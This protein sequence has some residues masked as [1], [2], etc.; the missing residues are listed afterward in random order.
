MKQILEGK[1]AIVTGSGQGIGRCIAL[2]MAS[3]GAKVITNNRKPGSSINAFEHTD[4]DFTDEEREELLKFN[5][6]A[7]TTADEII[8]MGGEAYPVFGD[9]SN[10]ENA[11]KLVDTA[12]E[13]WG[14]VDIIVNNA[15]S[16]W[17][18]NIMDMDVE[19]WDTQI[20]S[21]L[22]GTFY[23]MYYALPHMKEQGYGRII[24]S[25]SDAFVGI[26]DYAAYGAGN[27]GVVALS[28]AASK[29]LAGTG[30]TVNSYTP[31]ARTRSWYNARTSYR[32]Q[33]ISPDMIES[34]APEAMKRT[35]EGMVPF[36][37]YLASDLA[38]DITG[39][40]F[41]LAADGVIGLWSD[42]EIVKIIKDGSDKWTVEELE[43]RIK[44]EL[45]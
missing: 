14:R 35:A 13:K 26:N 36:L 27:A 43:K 45:L 30:I 1:V 18:G 19:V 33:G 15:S 32:I 25:A 42:P 21:K 12:M 44:S 8:A 5:G 20:N 41:Q 24:S 29:D 17:K 9:V 4:L 38:S 11:R 37:S 16:N 7:Q 23:L 40:N 3:L 34:M 6:D 22:S 31:L 10:R 2:D 28:K 39:N